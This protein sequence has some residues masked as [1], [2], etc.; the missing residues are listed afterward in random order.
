MNIYTL[1]GYAFLILGCWRI[2][3]DLK[4]VL[5]A[6]SRDMMF[7]LVRVGLFL[8]SAF[9]CFTYVREVAQGLLS[10]SVYENHQARY[11]LSGPHAL[12]FWLS[13]VS[14]SAPMAVIIPGINQRA[15]LSLIIVAPAVAYFLFQ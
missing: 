14:V 13:F 1:A 7:T 2:A 3:F 11:R 10:D 12:M 5:I 4:R 8:V 9:I 6:D 15:W